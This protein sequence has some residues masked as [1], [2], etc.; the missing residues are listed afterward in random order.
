VTPPH[1]ASTESFL[2]VG[3]TQKGVGAVG[4]VGSLSL[5]TIVDDDK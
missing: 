4:S 5:S 1:F 2:V 3:F